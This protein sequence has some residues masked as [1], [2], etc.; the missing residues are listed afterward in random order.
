MACSME[1]KNMYIYIYY[2]LTH[3]NQIFF[4]YETNIYNI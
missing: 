2:N 4:V 1:K 3:R